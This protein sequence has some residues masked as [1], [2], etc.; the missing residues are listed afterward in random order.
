MNWLSESLPSVATEVTGR[1][2]SLVLGADTMEWGW[3]N[4]ETER[5]HKLGKA[6]SLQGLSETPGNGGRVGGEAPESSYYKARNETGEIV[7]GD[8]T[9]SLNCL[10]ESQPG[11]PPEF[12]GRDCFLVLSIDTEGREGGLRQST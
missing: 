1:K 9:E 3:A 10:P 8:Q 4:R 5:V 7:M 6:G 2:C 12:P 11:W